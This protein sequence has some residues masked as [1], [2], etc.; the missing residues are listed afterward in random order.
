M[1]TIPAAN[2]EALITKVKAAQKQFATL[3]I[4]QFSTRSTEVVGADRLGGF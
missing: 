2:L 3:T 4:H 1:T